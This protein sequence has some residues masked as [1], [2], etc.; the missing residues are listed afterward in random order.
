LIPYGITGNQEWGR[1]VDTDLLLLAICIMVYPKG[2]C[3]DIV[4]FIFQEVGGVY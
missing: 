4:M 1:L 2:S 3:D